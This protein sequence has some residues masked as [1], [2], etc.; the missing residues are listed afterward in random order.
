[1]ISSFPVLSAE[2]VLFAMKM[3]YWN[4]QVGCDIQENY[5][6]IARRID[7]GIIASIPD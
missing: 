3:H 1:V 7:L 2:G 5:S 6:N 4:L